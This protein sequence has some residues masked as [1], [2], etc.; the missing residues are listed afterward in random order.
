MKL[1][2]RKKSVLRQIKLP[3]G[4]TIS[5]TMGSVSIDQPGCCVLKHVYENDRYE[6]ALAG[7]QPKESIVKNI[8]KQFIKL[9]PEF[10]MPD[11]QKRHTWQQF[12]RVKL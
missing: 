11:I 2:Y 8:L 10:E 1:F 3:K 6:W 7:D 4:C 5:E 9:K 12:K